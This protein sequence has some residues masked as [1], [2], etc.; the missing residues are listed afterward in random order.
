MMTQRLALSA[1]LKRDRLVVIASLAAIV[2]IAW[3]YTAHL[4]ADM[5]AMDSMQTGQEMAGPFTQSWGPADFIAMSVMWAVMMVAMMVPSAA[6]M[7]MAFASMDRRQRRGKD[8]L[9]STA[10]FAAGYAVIW[11]VFALATTVTQWGLHEATL[12]SPMMV[13]E[14]AV[15]G[16]VL[17]IGA[18]AYQLSPLKSACLNQCRSPLGF[19]M[20]E[21]RDGPKGALSMG[22]RHG[23]YC[24]GCC[25]MLMALL[26]V[27]GVMNL[28]WIAALSAFV[29][30]EKIVPG[31]RWLSR[32]SG[33]LL[34]VWGI[35]LLF[36]A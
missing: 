7:V 36:V 4:S 13:L 23:A 28:L 24:L 6:P 22:L 26:F 27:L 30:A 18:G 17:L 14:N 21:W 35:V 32:S 29:L 11:S 25:W 10:I 9:G 3:A 5:S 19:L 2:A 8:S 1:T 20:N 33:V 31:S 34:M 12:L 16:S 15:L